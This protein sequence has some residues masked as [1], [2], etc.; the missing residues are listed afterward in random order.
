MSK[1][2]RPL[3]QTANLIRAKF[4]P[5]DI[6][7]GAPGASA[8]DV[9]QSAEAM[10]AHILDPQPDPEMRLAALHDKMKRKGITLGD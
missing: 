5:A 8:E 9:A 1:F 10:A 3:Q 6:F 4:P 2:L 7:H